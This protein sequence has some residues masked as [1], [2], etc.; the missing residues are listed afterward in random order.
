MCN[1]ADLKGESVFIRCKQSSLG[2]LNLPM[3]VLFYVEISVAFF[4]QQQPLERKVLPTF[5]AGQVLW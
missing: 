4:L 2:D 1:D 5:R 3:L